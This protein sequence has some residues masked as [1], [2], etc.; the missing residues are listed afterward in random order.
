M[1]L[2]T[3]RQFV[4]GNLTTAAN[5]YSCPSN[6]VF[7][8]QDLVVTFTPGADNIL[9]IYDD[10]GTGVLDPILWLDFDTTGHAAGGGSDNNIHLHFE[11]G[12]PF[13]KGFNYIAT[14]SGVVT[15]C[16]MGYLL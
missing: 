7:I 13:G 16:A 4:T 8:L 11:N 2:N 1:P 14:V 6:K 3:I 5:L 10:T 12:I 9:K 15:I